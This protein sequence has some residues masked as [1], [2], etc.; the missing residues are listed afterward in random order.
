[1]KTTKRN[2]LGLA[3]AAALGTAGVANASETSSALRGKILNPQGEAAANV[4]IK[5]IHESS[6]TVTTHQTNE[7]GVFLAKGLRVGGPYKVII[8]SEQYQD[9][10]RDGIFLS[11]GQTSRINQQLESA[12][13]ETIQV[14]ASRFVQESGGF[15]QCV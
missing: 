5:V 12:S 15:K 8:D 13:M 4:T 7:A 6:G 10:T 14:T 9:V 1:M 2:L 3:I 11:L